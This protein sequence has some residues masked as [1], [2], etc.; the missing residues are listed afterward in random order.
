MCSVLYYI[1]EILNGNYV[2]MFCEVLEGHT[3][4]HAIHDMTDWG[5]SRVDIFNTSGDL[6]HRLD[7]PHPSGLAISTNSELLVT[8]KDGV[9]FH[10]TFWWFVCLYKQLYCLYV[11]PTV[12]YV[13]F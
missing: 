3:H 13:M 11:M 9:C 2:H 5:N 6:L 8:G 4:T 7:V 1:I 10:L 12:L